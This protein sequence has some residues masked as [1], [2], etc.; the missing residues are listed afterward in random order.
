MN[1]FVK[2]HGLGN[3]YIVMDSGNISFE[4]TP[5]RIRLIC[6]RHFGVGSD[7]ILLLVPSENADFGLRIFNPDG[8]EAE[9]SGNGIRIFSKFLYDHGYTNKSSF[10]VETIGGNVEVEL[11]IIDGKVS[12]VSVMMG[13]VTFMSDRIP[14]LGDPREVVGERIYVD[15]EELLITALSI[16]N[17]H[18]VVF[19][20]DLGSIDIGR[21]GPAIENHPL[22]PRRTNVQ[23]AKVLSKD[24]V[25]VEIWERGV[26][27][28][29]ASGSSACAVASAA[30]KNG[31]VDN[32]VTVKMK[33]GSLL[34][35]VKDDW[36]V[37]MSGPASEVYEGK[38]SDEFL[39]E[40]CR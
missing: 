25:E 11:V 13:Y 35:E 26:G 37:W 9:K 18:C 28:T 7:G 27:E 12:Q 32:R 10:S 38:L 34:V 16:G 2:S 22:F 4:L 6:D 40:L 36:A 14:V 20:E 5:E 15:G 19:V 39:E 29:L 21:L 33:G 23:F 8:S 31:L 17:P 30:L 24:E 1:E 3:D